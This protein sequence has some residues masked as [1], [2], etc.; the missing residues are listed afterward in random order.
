MNINGQA[1]YESRRLCSALKLSGAVGTNFIQMCQPI[2]K[3]GRT[4]V[5][6]DAVH[7]LAAPDY[8]HRRAL[9]AAYSAA[10][11]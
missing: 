10:R 1:F 4:W 3:D 7:A 2:Q 6:V 11:P 5:P 9:G 8:K